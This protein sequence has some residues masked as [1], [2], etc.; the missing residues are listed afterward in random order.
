MFQSSSIFSLPVNAAI[1]LFGAIALVVSSGYSWGPAL[2]LLIALPQLVLPSYWKYLTRQ[3]GIILA[4]LT[5]Y[6]LAAVMEVYYHQIGIR[7]LDRPSRFLAA[8]L[9]LPLLLKCTL[10]PMYFW[11]GVSL[12]G[13]FAGVFAAWLVVVMGLSRTEWEVQV[14]QFG[15]ICALLSLLSLSAAGWAGKQTNPR[16]WCGLLA[17]G[18]LGGAAGSVL[19]GS[20]GGWVAFVACLAIV[21]WGFR[22]RVSLKAVSVSAVAMV[23]L[24]TVVWFTPN[25]SLQAR[26][27]QALDEFITYSSGERVLTSVGARLEMWEAAMI[28]G[29]EKPLLG[30]GKFGYEIR[31][32]EYIAEGKFSDY[33]GS[34]THAHN[35]FLDAWSKRGAF[36][37]IALVL[38]FLLPAVAFYKGFSE[39]NPDTRSL[40]IAGFIVPSACALFSMSQGFFSHNSGAM[41]YSFMIVILWALFQQS[42]R[43]D[44]DGTGQPEP[45]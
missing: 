28:I 30:W 19:S 24:A 38:L 39:K 33:I 3:D 23:V 7:E 42:R 32:A 8:I 45:R 36:G 40:A 15:D 25:S 21:L 5:V 1:F 12:G 20:R 14:I 27:V 37:L 31:K 22:D 10:K 26:T 17:L 43:A 18:F 9:I 16:L 11:A 34:F 44:N 4:A 41:I 13:F 29:A 35:E 2:L 6:I